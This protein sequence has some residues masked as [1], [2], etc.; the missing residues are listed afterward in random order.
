MFLPRRMFEPVQ[1]CGL[2]WVIRE[3]AAKSV[4]D[5][6]G[7]W[8]LDRTSIAYLWQFELCLG[9]SIALLCPRCPSESAAICRGVL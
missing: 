1:G 3:L 9:E 7:F 6:C 8:Y 5:T 4:Q 2:K